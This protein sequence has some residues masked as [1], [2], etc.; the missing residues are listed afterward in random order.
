MCLE[1]QPL[2]ILKVHVWPGDFVDL[3]ARNQFVYR[4]GGNDRDEGGSSSPPQPLKFD[5]IHTSNVVDY[6]GL[7][8]LLGCLQPLMRCGDIDGFESSIEVEV[9]MGYARSFGDVVLRDHGPKVKPSDLE[10][11]LAVKCYSDN[12][13]Y[14][15][16]Y[17]MFKPV[18]TSQAKS[19]KKSIIA[20]NR[21]VC[22]CARPWLSL[23]LTTPACLI[24]TAAT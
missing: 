15:A 11:L 5:A 16:Q 19:A 20:S 10:R 4:K 2:D 8:P 24:R 21:A 13:T 18:R 6:V 3:C 23:L 12:P 17:L 22:Q 7:V 9:M 1:E 14:G